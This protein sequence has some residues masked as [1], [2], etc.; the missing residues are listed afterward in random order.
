MIKDGIC[1]TRLPHPSK[2]AVDAFLG[3]GRKGAEASL[4]MA[5]L[6]PLLCKKK[7][8]TLSYFPHRKLLSKQ[9]IADIFP[10]PSQQQLSLLCNRRAM[11]SKPPLEMKE[12]VLWSG[13]EL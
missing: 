11:V 4:G 9:G 6:A 10:H 8:G 1:M 2:Q 12:R 3:G 5:V 7:N 13:K